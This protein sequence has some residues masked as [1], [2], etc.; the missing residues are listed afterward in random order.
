MTD[1]VEILR[2]PEPLTN[3]GIE[4]RPNAPCYA[5]PR[6]AGDKGEIVCG[7][8][9]PRPAEHHRDAAQI[10]K[11]CRQRI[12]SFRAD[13]PATLTSRG[14]KACARSGLQKLRRNRIAAVTPWRR[15][16]CS[17]RCLW[18]RDPILGSRETVGSCEE[19]KDWAR[20][21]SLHY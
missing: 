12:A 3:R 1:A 8:G 6:G 16:S 20:V 9:E 15:S 13:R 17:R 2:E 5:L 21:V 10:A 14:L 11:A 19:S 7:L 4:A 18:K